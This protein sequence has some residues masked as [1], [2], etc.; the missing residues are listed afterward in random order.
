[1]WIVILLLAG[2]VGAVLLVAA[3]RPNTFRVERSAVVK[4]APEKVFALVNDMKAFNTWN[5]W[6]RME[7]DAKLSYT[8]PAQGVGAAYSWDGKKT[9]AGRMEVLESMPSSKVG[10]KLEFLRPFPGTNSAEFTFAPEAG[11]TRITWAM[12]GNLAFV[13]KVMGLFFSMD[14]MI[15]KSFE[16]GL[17]NLKQIAEK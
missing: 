4:A 14:R 2:I 17:A 15:G 9:G 12:L 16:D 8:G 11:G 5:P 13:P 6:L 10:F 3:M 7:P 1:M